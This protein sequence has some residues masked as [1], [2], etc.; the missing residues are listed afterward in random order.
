MKFAKRVKELAPTAPIIGP[1]HYHYDGW[2]TWHASMN[3]YSDF[4]R[5]YM[6]D[7]LATVRAESEAIGTRLLDTWDFHWYPQ[8]VFNGT[9][10]WAIDHAK[11]PMIEAEITRSCK[12]RAATGIPITTSTRGSRTTTSSAPRTS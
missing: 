5:W 6:D 10:T 3:E 12:A 2:T 9:F 4:G 11:R 8:R 7:F 1:D